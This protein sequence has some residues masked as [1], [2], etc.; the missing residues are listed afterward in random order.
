M[1]KTLLSSDFFI[2]IWAIVF[3]FF[4]FLEFFLIE[5]WWRRLGLWRHVKAK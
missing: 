4:I 2:Y 3:C 1:L 5:W